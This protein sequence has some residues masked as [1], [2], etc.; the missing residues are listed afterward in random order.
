VPI[1]RNPTDEQRANAE[2]LFVVKNPLQMYSEEEFCQ[3]LEQARAR[4]LSLEKGSP[5]E[6]LT[7]GELDQ[8]LNG[9]TKLAN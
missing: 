5:L 9:R 3:L 8:M 6:Q 7:V 4:G 2:T 1:N